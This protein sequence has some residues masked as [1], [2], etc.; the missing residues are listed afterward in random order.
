M[1]WYETDCYIVLLAQVWGA[2]VQLLWT[3]S[4]MMSILILLCRTYALSY[5]GSKVISVR[6]ETLWYQRYVSWILALKNDT[7]GVSYVVLYLLHV[8]LAPV[9]Y[10][11][12]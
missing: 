12:L 8:L 10:P 4:K 6:S 11:L 5:H 7:M 3:F 1:K 2:K 9:A